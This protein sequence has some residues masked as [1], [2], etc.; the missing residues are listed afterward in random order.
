[1]ATFLIKISGRPVKHFNY[2]YLCKDLQ[3]TLFN[4]IEKES[5]PLL[6]DKTLI[7]RRDQNDFYVYTEPTQNIS[8]VT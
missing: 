5:D 4:T 7:Y 3:A 6:K 2:A 1:M 8:A